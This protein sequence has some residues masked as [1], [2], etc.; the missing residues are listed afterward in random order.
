MCTDA[1]IACSLSLD[2][3]HQDIAEDFFACLLSGLLFLAELT[4]HAV[5]SSYFQW[6]SAVC[7]SLFMTFFKLLF[8]CVNL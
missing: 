2:A 1:L 3:R 4:G 6:C 5:K 7:L 8:L